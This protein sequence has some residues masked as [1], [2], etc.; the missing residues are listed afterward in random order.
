MLVM[1]FLCSISLLIHC[2][3]T[4]QERFVVTRV[5][6]GDTYVLDDKRS[7][8]LIGI[9]T[10]EKNHPT[11]P[12]EFF[13]EEATNYSKSLVEGKTVFLEYDNEKLD[14]YGRTLAYIYLEDGTLINKKLIEE[15][16]AYAYVRFPFQKMD[17]FVAAEKNAIRSLK[18]LWADFGKNELRW[19]MNQK[20]V[21]VEVIEMS[22]KAWGICYGKYCRLR[23]PDDLFPTELSN[24]RLW[25]NSLSPKDLEDTLLS[26]NWLIFKETENENY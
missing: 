22:N 26:N 18:G 19:I 25:I 21:P 11:K 20:K 1:L 7:I 23:I 15:G 5:I 8:R 17:E 9:D 16:Y 6:D 4:N 3:N 2:K 13:A 14:K 10:P 12:L 24:L